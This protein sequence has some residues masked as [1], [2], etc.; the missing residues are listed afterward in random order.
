M[1]RLNKRE[2][3]ILERINHDLEIVNRPRLE[4]LSDNESSIKKEV[5]KKIKDHQ[6]YIDKLHSRTRFLAKMALTDES[7]EINR[8]S[9]ICVLPVLH[10]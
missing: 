4:E 9:C 5:R 2:N 10:C 1:E 7:L 3:D 6:Q 8:V